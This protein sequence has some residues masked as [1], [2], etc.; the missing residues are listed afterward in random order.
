MILYVR[1]ILGVLMM[2]YVILLIINVVRD[3]FKKR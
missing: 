1:M 2:I 3:M